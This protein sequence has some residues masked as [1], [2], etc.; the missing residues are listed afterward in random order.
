MTR[1]L[2]VDNRSYVAR[3]FFGILQSLPVTKESYFK[4]STYHVCI[5]CILYTQYVSCIHS[6]YHVF[7]GH[8]YFR[9]INYDFM[10]EKK[11][12]NHVLL[13]RA[14]QKITQDSHLRSHPIN[15][16]VLIYHIKISTNIH[17]KINTHANKQHKFYF[18]HGYH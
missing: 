5:V 18:S 11:Q 15:F 12:E 10:Y 4:F 2:L 9:I 13:R 3:S 1:F 16:H 8:A 6:M 14:Y 7:V 17:Q